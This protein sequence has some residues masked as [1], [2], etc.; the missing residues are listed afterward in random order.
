MW[1]SKRYLKRTDSLAEEGTIT[2]SSDGCSEAAGT[3]RSRSAESYSPYGYSYCAPVGEQV[4]IVNSSSGAVSAGT[5]MKSSQLL[6]GEVSL[7][8]LGGASIMLKNNGDV[9]INGVV[10]SKDGRIF[11]ISGEEIE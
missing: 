3:L 4:L 6:Q 2:V 5:K 10:I 1:L 8:S 9:V 7:F 11:G